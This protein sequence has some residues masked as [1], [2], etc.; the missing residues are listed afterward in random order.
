MLMKES[1]PVPRCCTW[2]ALAVEAKLPSQDL[3][4]PLITLV[5]E[6]VLLPCL[7]SNE[8]KNSVQDPDSLAIGRTR[9]KNAPILDKESLLALLEKPQTVLA[10]PQ[11]HKV[12]TV[13][14]TR[15]T[16]NCMIEH[17]HCEGPNREANRN[18]VLFHP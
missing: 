6:H 15:N 18:E 14:Q 11:A 12:V 1:R 16:A 17:A 8:S 3:T 13:H 4:M 5:G 2:L 10:S 7:A 9:P